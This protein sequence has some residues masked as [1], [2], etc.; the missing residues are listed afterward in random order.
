MRLAAVELFHNEEAK[1]VATDI[2]TPQLEQEVSKIS[3]NVYTVK[4]D[5]NFR[6]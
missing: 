6:R 4:L 2:A 3:K 5:V 1:V